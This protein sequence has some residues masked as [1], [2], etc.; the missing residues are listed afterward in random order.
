MDIEEFVN[1]LGQAEYAAVKQAI[2]L[3]KWPDGRVLASD[4]RELLMR[5]MIA[6]ENKH[7]APDQQTG[8][9]EQP[10]CPST[11]IAGHEQLLKWRE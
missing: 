10:D 2:E 7:L 9:M 1:R 4:D 3:G 6:W 5:A 11:P 8:Y